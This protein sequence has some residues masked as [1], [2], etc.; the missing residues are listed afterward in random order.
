MVP[1]IIGIHR[2][3]MAL[4]NGYEAIA[5]PDDADSHDECATSY[6]G[7]ICDLGT[8]AQT[9]ADT[10]R[11]LSNARDALRLEAATK[12]RLANQVAEKHLYNACAVTSDG[13]DVVMVDE[14]IPSV[15][16]IEGPWTGKYS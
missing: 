2:R 10:I 14:G 8:E 15:H 1:T 9:A 16:A 4:T 11:D 13:K 12:D 6:A 3:L 7:A 5:L